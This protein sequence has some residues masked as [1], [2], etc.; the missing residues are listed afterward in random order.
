MSDKRKNAQVCQDLSVSNSIPRSKEISVIMTQE[1]K[2]SN[3]E[4]SQDQRNSSNLDETKALRQVAGSE[5]Q[6]GSEMLVAKDGTGLRLDAPVTGDG[7]QSFDCLFATY[8]SV[9]NSQPGTD[10]IVQNDGD[11][12]GALERARRYVANCAP[13]YKGNRYNS[14]SCISS[15]LHRIADGSVRLN[16][17]QVFELLQSWNARNQEPLSKEEL[18]KVLANRRNTESCI[19]SDWQTIAG[20]SDELL[21]DDDLYEYISKCHDREQDSLCDELNEAAVGHRRVGMLPADKSH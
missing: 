13:A 16:D 7:P 15:H 3:F 19:S 9:S 6:H 5:M 2:L 12:Q 10:G 18:R 17:E 11:S 8:M 21:S 1:N 4:S 14:A 20:D